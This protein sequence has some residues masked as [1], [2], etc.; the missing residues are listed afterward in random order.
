MI[1]S[2]FPSFLII[3]DAVTSS[4]IAIF[5]LTATYICFCI[6]GILERG[7][8][9][10]GLGSKSFLTYESNILFALRFM[11]DCNIVGGNWLEVPAGKYRKAARI[12]SYCQ[13]E[14]DCLY[15]PY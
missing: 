15:P 13:L 6:L 1:F 9:M 2:L 14:L 4:I 8:T 10:E 11:I 7:I 12:M 5:W 3:L